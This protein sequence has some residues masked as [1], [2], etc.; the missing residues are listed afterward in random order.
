MT[1]SLLAGKPAQQ[2]ML[3]DPPR[4]E[5]DPGTSGHRGRDC[6]KIVGVD[7]G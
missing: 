7:I 5:H 2:D 1:I 3:I 6:R 4:L